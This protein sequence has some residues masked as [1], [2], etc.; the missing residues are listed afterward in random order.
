MS[1]TRRKALK[2]GLITLASPFIARSAFAQARTVNV[3][4]W[5]DYIGETTLA[6]FEAATG[7]VP[8]YDLYDSAE[9]AE[10]KLMAGKSG[11]DVVVTAGRNLPRFAA[12]GIMAPLDKALLP[13]Y[14]HLDPAIM[15]T[16]DPLDPG[17]AFAIPYMWGTTGVTVNTRMVEEVLP[18]ADY[19]TFELIFNPANAEKLQACG[20]NMIDSPG[21][22]IPM[23]LAYL[24][25][26]PMSQDPADLEAVVEAFAK[27]RPYIRSFD[28]NAYTA[29]LANEQLC[30]TTNWAGDYAVAASRAAEAGLDV[31]LRYDVPLTGGTLWVDAFIVPADAPHKEE[32]H[33]FINY[34]LEPEVIAKATNYTAY[35]NANKDA[36][37]F[38]DPAILGNPAVYPD[39]TVKSRIW[40]P[41][42]VSP[43]YDTARTRAWTRIM[44]GA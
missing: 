23:V 36:G 15:A 34:M 22:I 7:I 1:I 10:A 28:N 12:A 26:D 18:G 38:T 41:A 6:D 2:A 19:S 5:A 44:T 8:V 42:A 14:S 13:N 3:Y 25:K 16:L 27:I 39:E 9:A 40:L 24:G 43:E 11:Y 33:A 37:P 17:N 29:N 21:T 31:P 4:N 20:I 30:V 32:A 35:A